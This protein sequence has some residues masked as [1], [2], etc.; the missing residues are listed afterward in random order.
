[1]TTIHHILPLGQHRGVAA[2]HLHGL[3]LATRPELQY[4][5]VCGLQ[6]ARAAWSHVHTYGVHGRGVHAQPATSC[7]SCMQ[8]QLTELHQLCWIQHGSTTQ[9]TNGKCSFQQKP[10]D[11]H[12]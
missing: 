3:R 8:L 10:E 11:L 9:L 6:G 4:C 2:A 7:N 12:L 5:V 1:M